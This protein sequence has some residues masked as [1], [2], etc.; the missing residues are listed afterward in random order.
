[1]MTANVNM[2]A[3]V[4]RTQIQLTEAQMERLKRL[5]RDEERAVAAIIRAAVQDYLERHEGLRSRDQALA[6]IGRFEADA[7][8]VAANHDRYLAEIYGDFAR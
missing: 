1:M 2:E 4:F 6:A 5:A 3:G 7:G 8:D